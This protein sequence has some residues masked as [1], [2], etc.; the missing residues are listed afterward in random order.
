MPHSKVAKTLGPVLLHA[1]KLAFGIQKHSA[2]LIVDSGPTTFAQERVVEDL[3]PT[4][5]AW[6]VRRCPCHP[7]GTRIDLPA[8]IRDE[9]LHLNRNGNGVSF[10]RVSSLWPHILPNELIILPFVRIMWWC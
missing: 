3:R 6:L 7:L 8:V 5:P 1:V 10:T 2:R 9:T 4:H